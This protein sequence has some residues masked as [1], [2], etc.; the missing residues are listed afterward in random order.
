MFSL[1]DLLMGEVVTMPFVKHVQS[2]P[3]IFFGNFAFL[4][5]W[6]GL[7]V[8]R[9]LKNWVVATQYFYFHPYLGKIFQ[10]G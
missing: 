3:W 5:G 6:A 4:I 10:M 9:D 7:S 8:F 1:D 2:S